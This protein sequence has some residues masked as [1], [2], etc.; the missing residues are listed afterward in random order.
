ME[1]IYCKDC[2]QK[3]T[4]KDKICPNCGSKNKAY[5]IKVEEKIE[6]HDQIKGK[7]KRQGFRRP[8]KELIFPHPIYKF[9]VIFLNIHAF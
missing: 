9:S 2:G 4:I 6:L 3:L 8:I 1:E 5:K 7:V